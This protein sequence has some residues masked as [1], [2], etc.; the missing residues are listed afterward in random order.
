MS[1][2]AAPPA[3]IPMEITNDS[4][5]SY[6]DARESDGPEL[7]TSEAIS[8]DAAGPS[9]T[10]IPAPPSP[11]LPKLN[12]KSFPAIDID[13]EEDDSEDD[14]PVATLPI[15]MSTALGNQFDL[16][17]YPLQHRSI[18]VPSW[19]RD[20][21]K[22][23][24]ARVKEKINRVEIEIPVDAGQSYW[25]EE[26]ARDLGFVTDTR[27]ING[28][29]GDDIVG[30]YGFG[31]GSKKE[32]EGKKDGK[33]K[34]KEKWG[35]KM[36]LRSEPVPNATGYYSGVIRDGALHLHPISKLH[37]FRTSLGY[38]D[39]ADEKAKER[40][41]RRAANGG[42]GG[43]SDDEKNDKKKAAAKPTQQPPQR[44]V[45]DEEDNDGSGSIKD[46]RNKM[47]WMTK[48]EDE[49]AWVGYKWRVGEDEEV[50]QTLEKLIVPEDKRERLTCKTRPL[51]YL[52]RQDKMQIV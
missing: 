16:Y 1:D 4:I 47:W 12:T 33:G 18:N 14:E 7:Q 26:R 42:T 21:G 15:Y 2:Q 11:P 51:D 28:D 35:D 50:S 43:D 36:R 39:D 10:F 25:R 17:Q 37:Q 6:P 48:K 3:D 38:L 49:D 34:G 8:H 45:L 46:F 19:A 32:K 13:S 44:K 41:T 52:D 23:I 22:Y 9:N 30:G 5:N 27:E 29:G 20:R 31:G 24:S 40:S